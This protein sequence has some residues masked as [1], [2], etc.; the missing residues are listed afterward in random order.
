MLLD[1]CPHLERY[2]VDAQAGF[3]LQTDSYP[4]LPAESLLTSGAITK[5]SYGKTPKQME[6]GI[7]RYRIFPAATVQRL[8]C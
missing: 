2:K 7:A 8:H 3:A 5:Q 4:L 6:Q 1:Q